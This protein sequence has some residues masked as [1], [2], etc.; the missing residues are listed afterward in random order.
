MHKQRGGGKQVGGTDV[1]LTGNQIYTI[2]EHEILATD[3]R[4]GEILQKLPARQIVI[5]GEIAYIA[6]KG[7][8]H[9]VEHE[10]YARVFADGSLRRKVDQLEIELR[11]HAAVQLQQRIAESTQ[12]LA[13]L[14][15]ERK[16]LAE[17]GQRG[18]EVDRGLADEVAEFEKAR[19][20]ASAAL[21]AAAADFNAKLQEAFRLRGIRWRTSLPHEASLIAVGNAIIAGGEGEIAA[22]SRDDGKLL[23]RQQ[24]DGTARG[25]AFADG[26]LTVSTTSGGVY[27]FGDATHQPQSAVTLE[28]DPTAAAVADAAETEVSAAAAS[29]ILAAS[30]VE[31]GYCLVVGSEEGHLAYELVNQSPLKV[32][33]VEADLEKVQRSRER[34]RKAGLYGTR[35][36]VDYAD[37]SLLPYPNYFANLIVSESLLRG[38]LPPSDPKFVASHLKP[39]GG[40]ICLLPA[41]GEGIEAERQWLE[42]TGLLTEGATLETREGCAVL[43]RAALPG[44]DSWTHQHG[45]AAN[46]SSTND[47]RVQGGLSVL[48]YGDPGPSHMLNRHVGAVGPVSAGG[49]LFIQGE[50]TVMA[51]DAY[52]GEFQ[53]EVANSGAIRTGVFNN[54]EP[55]NLVASEDRVYNVIDDTCLELDA[56][57]GDIMRKY[58]VP[59]PTQDPHLQWGYLAY[60]DGILYG[61]STR[62]ELVPPE[63]RNLRGRPANSAASDR[64]FAYDTLTGGLLW[65][66]EGKSIAHTAVAIGGGRV[67]FIDSSITPAEREELLQQ[68]KTALRDLAGKEREIAEQRLK[69][70]DVR[71]AVAIDART[72]EE[73]WSRAVDVTD[74]SGVGTGAG[75]LA[76][77]VH[78]GFVV[79]CGANANG[80]YW[81]QFLSGEFARRRLVVL[82]AETGDRLWARDAN[83][84]HR[85]IVVG[86]RIIAEPWAFELATGAAGDANASAD[87]RRDA[88]DVYSSWPPLR[89]DFRDTQHALLPF[90]VSRPI[91][92]SS[93]TAGRITSAA[94]AW[95]AGSIRFRP[96]GWCSSPRQVQGVRVCFR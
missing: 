4:A 61:T 78:D 68:D 72:G 33:C 73:L 62:R 15:S 32:Y 64:I 51:Y 8:I 11:G 76:I 53:W 59:N 65:E 28:A 74:C 93:K 56:A 37:L 49:R 79:L 52:N 50:K 40:V 91:T 23:W 18:S 43:T 69:E 29:S 41:P 96:A 38:K 12:E 6:S 75:Q 86:T 14:N 1:V 84:R 83:Y 22:L 19:A 55:G 24:V 48:W 46:T 70:Y 89:R 34:F 2:G 82:S 9:A 42:G 30:G 67:V 20:E 92:T 54:Y 71:R 63:E 39:V 66:Y 81:D 58:V 35:V 17:A 31:R 3:Q 57:T 27:C 90:W 47:Q 25:L 21:P 88:V 95:A 77:M 36:V 87:G 60:D 13:R 16:E 26:L 44:T 80:H 7:M 45:N 94:I 10:T 5:D 85:P